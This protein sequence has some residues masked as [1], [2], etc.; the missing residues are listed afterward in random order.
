MAPEKQEQNKVA[1]L[2]Q[3]QLIR[4][5]FRKH[6]LAVWA[7]YLL[8]MLYMIAI[9]CEVVAPWTREWSNLE[10]AYCPPQLIRFTP[11]RGL[12]T[13]AMKRYVNPVTFEKTYFIDRDDWVPLKFFARG[14]KYKLWGVIPWDRHLL[15][16]DN[17]TYTAKNSAATFYLLGADRYGRDIFSRILYGAR[18]SL[19]LGLIGIAISFAIGCIVGG[20]S[21]YVGGNVDMVIQRVIEIITSLPRLPMWL[22]MGAI[23]P[24]DWSPLKVYFAMTL[25]LAFFGWPRLARVVR[26][27]LLAL[28]EE[29]YATAAY[30]LGAS[31]PR[32]IFRHLLPGFASYIIVRVTLSVPAMILG[33][34]SLSFLGLGLRPPI[35]SW[36]VMLQDCMNVTAVA[37]YPWLMMPVAF[38]IVTVLAFNFAG[39]GL[40][41]AADP[42]SSR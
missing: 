3:W 30:L 32:I 38:I 2:S 26:G 31:K 28:R 36:G 42:Y 16:V 20:I 24:A 5:R 12:Y 39:D 23:V 4:R 6:R 21:G 10:R 41:D 7:G 15:T 13:Y 33:E 40:R 37:H 1:S 8:L 35:V 19:S 34:T 27:K 17:S 9:F 25:V 14:E 11:S 29:D 18:V 22:A